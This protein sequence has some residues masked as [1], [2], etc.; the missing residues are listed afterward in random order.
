MGYVPINVSKSGI[1]VINETYLIKNIVTKDLTLDHILQNLNSCDVKEVLYE[2]YVDW[3]FNENSEYIKTDQWKDPK[4]GDFFNITHIESMIVI[5]SSNN[6]DDEIF[7]CKENIKYNISSKYLNHDFEFF[8]S[9]FEGSFFSTIGSFHLPCVRGFYNGKS[10]KL[11][12]SC[13]TALITMI[14]M[15][16]KYFASTKSDPIEIINK[17]RNRGFAIILTDDEKI[18]FADYVIRVEKLNN[19]Y[20]KINKKCENHINNIFG[21]KSINDKFFRPRITNKEYYTKYRSVKDD[22]NIKSTK[23]KSVSEL[24][25]IQLYNNFLEKHNHHNLKFKEIFGLFN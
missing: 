10:V 11:L 24:S 1:I 4:Y 6:S 15:D 9:K 7:V 2:K 8:K 13:V 14:N 20:G 18:K 22:Y 16:Y 23:L 12:P 19:L 21:Y 25:L 17:Y 3:K 5:L